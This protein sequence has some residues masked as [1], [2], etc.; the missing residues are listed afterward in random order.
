MV[1]GAAFQAEGLA[2]AAAERFRNC[3]DRKKKNLTTEARRKPGPVASLIN[4]ATRVLYS[5]KAPLARNVDDQINL[6][7]YG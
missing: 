7:W 5:V 4:N 6:A 2:A 3:H 1:A